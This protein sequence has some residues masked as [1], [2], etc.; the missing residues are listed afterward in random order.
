M[1][2]AVYSVGGVKN[3]GVV[4]ARAAP[5][6]AAPAP[7]EK[8]VIAQEVTEKPISPRIRQDS[9]SATVV[10]EFVG[11]NGEVSQQV[12]SVAALAYLRAGLTAQGTPKPEAE[13]A[14]ADIL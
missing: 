2:S 3:D 13:A 11:S 1:L 9:I 6:A 5:P 7:A 4:S 14:K 10:T 12:P 8:N